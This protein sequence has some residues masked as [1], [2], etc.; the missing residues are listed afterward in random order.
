MHNIHITV[1]MYDDKSVRCSNQQLLDNIL[2]GR[3]V[4]A[5]MCYDVHHNGPNGFPWGNREESGLSA[6]IDELKDFPD[7]PQ[8]AAWEG[9]YI[10][11]WIT[12]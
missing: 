2:A 6:L 7:T 10:D 11:I 12:M 8:C 1:A 9:K 3:L 4:P 5:R